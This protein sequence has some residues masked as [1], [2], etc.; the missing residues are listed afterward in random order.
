MVARPGL[1]S[2]RIRAGPIPIAPGFQV[3]SR[4][5]LTGSAGTD[6][7]LAERVLDPEIG[8][9]RLQSRRANPVDEDDEPA[10]AEAADWIYLRNGSAVKIGYVSGNTDAMFDIITGETLD[11][12]FGETDDAPVELEQATLDEHVAFLCGESTWT[13]NGSVPADQSISAF[14]DGPQHR[15]ECPSDSGIQSRPRDGR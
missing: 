10:D 15:R 2:P 12:E 1:A 14:P 4:V 11:E 9:R 13:C 7:A 5:V 6:T 8:L 3:V